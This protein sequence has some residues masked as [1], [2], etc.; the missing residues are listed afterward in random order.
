TGKTITLNE[1]NNWTHTWTDLAE[2]AKGKTI[3]Y[4]VR[5]NNK[6]QNYKVTVN[7]RNI[8]NMMIINTL[9][10]DQPTPKKPKPN[11]PNNSN[12][13]NKPKPNDTNKSEHKG[14][15][16]DNSSNGLPQTGEAI[17]KSWIT[18]VAILLLVA[19]IFLIRRKR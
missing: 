19:G 9:I 8:G 13:L 12:D 15:N 7:D 3:S 18:W 14:Q 16:K 10:D 17:A 2:K 4:S 6:K 5:E 1:S 11:E